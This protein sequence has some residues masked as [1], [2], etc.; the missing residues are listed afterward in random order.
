[1]KIGEL[2][3]VISKIEISEKVFFNPDEVG[4]IVEIFEPTINFPA[5]TAIV[6]YSHG[7]LRCFLREL[8]II[9]KKS[10]LR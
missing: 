5:E 10:E 6:Q 3:S 9:T 1:M 4:V 2:V 8:E 7:H